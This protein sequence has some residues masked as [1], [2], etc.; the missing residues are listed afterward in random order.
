MKATRETELVRAVKQCLEL[1]G[2]LAIRVNSG[3]FAGTH[4]GRRRWV[5]INSEPGCSDLVC[6]WQG[7]FL[8]IECKLPGMKATPAQAAF[9]ELVRLKGG[10]AGVVRD[11]DDLEKLLDEARQV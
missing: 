5:R 11:L 1:R 10:V 4:R 7:I 2:A 3:A 6:C 9:L 8:A